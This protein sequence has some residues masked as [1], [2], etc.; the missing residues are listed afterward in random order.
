[1]AEV[2][3]ARW[4]LRGLLNAA[5]R[6]PVGYMVLNA[7]NEYVGTV[8]LSEKAA[9]RAIQTY[10]MPGRYKVEPVFGRN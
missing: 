4:A 5:K 1:M 10:R 8:H 3:K 6:P 7:Y 2:S 9:K